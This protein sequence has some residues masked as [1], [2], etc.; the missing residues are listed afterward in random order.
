MILQQCP[1]ATDVRPL[2]EWN[3]AGHRMRKGTHQIKIWAPTFRR[4]PAKAK[5]KA[6]PSPAG[7]A[8]DTDD[9]DGRAD[10]V[11]TRFVLVNVVD[12]S[13]LE[14]P[15]QR[16]AP[17]IPVELRGDAPAGLWDGVAALIHAEGFTVER[18]DC[19]GPY[20]TTDWASRTVRVR[21]DVEPAQAA[22]TLT[23]ESAHILCGHEHRSDAPRGLREV[24]AESVACIVTAVSGLD[25]L[26][27]SVPYVAGW[28]TDRETAHASAERVLTVADRI[29][30]ALGAP[31]PD[32]T[33]QRAAAPGRTPAGAP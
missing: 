14:S 16:A 25:T 5:A 26:P 17:P 24:E 7:P 13:Q 11:L 12:A 9:T 28:A 3:A 6:T 31:P 10:T 15:P 29:L 30:T 1:E 4:S 8:D 22:K 2:S 33:G 32:R 18:G 27:Y 20:G 23:H 19:G 21:G